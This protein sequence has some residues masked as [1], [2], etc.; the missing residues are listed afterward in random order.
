MQTKILFEA[1][2]KHSK[3]T[4][5]RTPAWRIVYSI[6]AVQFILVWKWN[7]PYTEPLLGFTYALLNIWLIPE[8]Y[9]P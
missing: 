5:F 1:N 7:A 6:Q 4:F 8:I 3:S 2:S 9:L